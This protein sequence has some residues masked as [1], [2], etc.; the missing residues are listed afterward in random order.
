MLSANQLNECLPKFFMG[1]ISFLNDIAEF[2]TAPLLRKDFIIDEYQILEAKARGADAV[3]LIAEALSAQQV[4]ELSHI[5]FE[6]DIEVLL[7]IHSA[8]QIEKIDSVLNKTVGINNRDLETFN[9]DINTT[10]EIVKL[11][12]DDIVVVSES[13]INK[14]AD[15]NNLKDTRVNAVLVGEHF[16]TS[17]SVDAA[18]Q[19]FLK[20]CE[21]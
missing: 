3:L 11:L 14:E 13:G 20:W 2:K 1:N 10:L 12:P 16:M 6:T 5:A 21:R 9:V 8:S 18:L 4:H 15:V 17:I 19:Q 7:E